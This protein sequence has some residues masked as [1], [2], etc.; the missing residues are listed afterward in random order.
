MTKQTII[1]GVGIAVDG[2]TRINRLELRQELYSAPIA[3]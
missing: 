1:W 3:H 2:P